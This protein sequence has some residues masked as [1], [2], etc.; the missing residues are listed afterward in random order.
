MNDLNIDLLE[1][2]AMARAYDT[3]KPDELENSSSELSSE[4][5]KSSFFRI[6]ELFNATNESRKKILQSF[7]YIKMIDCNWCCHY[8]LVLNR[9]VGIYIPNDYII[10]YSSTLDND[11]NHGIFLF[12]KDHEYTLKY[13]YLDEAEFRQQMNELDVVSECIEQFESNHQK[14]YEFENGTI[15]M[16]QD[17]YLWEISGY[18]RNNV[19]EYFEMYAILIGIRN[20]DED[21]DYLNLIFKYLY[22]M[23]K[24]SLNFLYRGI[25][26]R[27]LDVNE[28]D[29]QQFNEDA[30]TFSIDN[31]RYLKVIDSNYQQFNRKV[32]QDDEIEKIQ[33]YYDGKWYFRGTFKTNVLGTYNDGSLLEFPEIMNS[34]ELNEIEKRELLEEI[35]NQKQ[36]ELYEYKDLLINKFINNIVKYL[37]EKCSIND[38]KNLNLIAYIKVEDIN[39][40]NK[41]EELVY[42][43][44]KYVIDNNDIDNVIKLVDV[45]Y[46]TSTVKAEKIVIGPEFI[47]FSCQVFGQNKIFILFE[48]NEFIE[49]K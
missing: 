8:I 31:K 40:E 19:T 24:N 23:S 42:N 49:W 46:L 32:E 2:E 5:S 20:I 13:T 6:S 43:H 3:S 36:I 21:N 15:Y 9:K 14:F 18:S 38:W 33:V 12:L 30:V 47:A 4:Q 27:K 7:N 28:M 10:I 16:Y 17:N 11:T 44:L 29:N 45:D 48:N 35:I 25:D 34:N 26:L 1:H 39:I 37:K 41:T 22:Q